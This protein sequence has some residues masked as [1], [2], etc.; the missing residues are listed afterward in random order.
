MRCANFGYKLNEKDIE[1]CKQTLLNSYSDDVLISAFVSTVQEENQNPTFKHPT[2]W[3]TMS[4][5]EKAH[6]LVKVLILKLLAVVDFSDFAFKETNSLFQEIE[7]FLNQDIR[8]E[9]NKTKPDRHIEKV[10][11]E[12]METRSGIDFYRNDQ[13]DQF[14]SNANKFKFLGIITDRQSDLMRLKGKALS[15]KSWSKG[16]IDTVIRNIE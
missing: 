6:L 14:P 12:I 11:E 1:T 10:R 8:L 16:S 5:I 15:F 9:C 3:N 13:L 7:Q 4:D 2:E